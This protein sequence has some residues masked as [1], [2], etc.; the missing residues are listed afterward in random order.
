MGGEWGGGGDLVAVLSSL[1]MGGSFGGKGWGKSKGD[2]L[3]DE[4]RKTMETL[5]KIENDRKVWIGGL[6]KGKTWKDLDKF[7]EEHATK[8]KLVNIM[9]YGKGVCAFKTEEEATAAIAA[10]NRKEMDGK[11]LEV[12]AWTKKE[13]KDKEAEPVTEKEKKDTTKKAKK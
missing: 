8:P 1:G 7:I 2:K 6:P 4:S 13:K 12:D 10:L 5:K 3:R 9:S 11:T